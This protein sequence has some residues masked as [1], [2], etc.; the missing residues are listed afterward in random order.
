M[1]RRANYVSF[2][3]ERVP[4]K[5]MNNNT[6]R[7]KK[8]KNLRYDKCDEI[9]QRALDESRKVEWKKWT[10]FSAATIVMG[11]V[12]QE[13]RDAGHKM[14]PTQW[15]ETDRNEHK[16][17]PDGPYVPIWAHFKNVLY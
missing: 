5:G 12:L 3:A 10:Q 11:G 17:R 15:I 16:R 9:T 13:L 4:A 1:E 2:M 6:R 8:A 14:M 7:S